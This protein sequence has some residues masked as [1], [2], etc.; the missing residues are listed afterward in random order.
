MHRTPNRREKVFGPGRWLPL[1]REAKVRIMHVAR[2][3]KRATEKGKHFGAVTGKAVDVLHALLWLIHDGRSGQCNPAYETI[4]DK[5]ACARSTVGEAIRMLEIAG[6][7]TWVNRITR[8]R[9]RERDLFGQWVT[10]WRVVRT[11]NAYTFRDPTAAAQAGRGS[12]TE[13]RSGPPNDFKNNNQ[14]PGLPLDLTTPLGRALSRYGAA[15]GATSQE[16]H[17]SA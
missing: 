9:V 7:L 10:S 16:P 5:A 1:D 15:L 8:I 11:S 17:A 13:L 2:C 12:K 3:L 14:T 6:L 4:S